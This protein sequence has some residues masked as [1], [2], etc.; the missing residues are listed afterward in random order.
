LKK[1]EVI[2]LSP[3]SFKDSLKEASK[4]LK[5]SR[6]VALYPE[7]E[8]SSDDELSEFKAG[9]KLL[10]GGD[11]CV[12]VPFFIDGV[13]GSVFARNKTPQHNSFFKRRVI[14]VSFG[15][16]IVNKVDAHEL[17]KIVENI[18]DNMA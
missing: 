3:K 6:L 1:A 5:D 17:Q 14:N 15:K 18:R 7:G 4:R 2:P 9:Y 10:D 16:P 11:K 8:I 12:I 13:F